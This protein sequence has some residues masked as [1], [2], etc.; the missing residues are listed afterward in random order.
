MRHYST[1]YLAEGYTEVCVVV[2]KALNKDF[3][4][5]QPIAPFA[6]PIKFP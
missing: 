6:S 3:V 1:V 4:W 5:A 2:N